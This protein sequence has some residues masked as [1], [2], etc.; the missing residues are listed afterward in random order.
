MRLKG[1]FRS[2]LASVPLVL[3]GTAAQGQIPAFPGA[4][5]ARAYAIGGRGSDVYHVVNLSDTGPGSLRYGV[6]DA[7]AAGRAIVFEVSGWI[8]IPSGG[9]IRVT[10]PKITIAGQT[11]PSDGVGLYNGTFGRRAQ[12]SSR[13]ARHVHARHRARLHQHRQARIASKEAANDPSHFHFSRVEQSVPTFTR[14]GDT[15]GSSRTHT[16][17][18]INSFLF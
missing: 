2:V 9:R 7:P 14:L 6:E 15:A 1:R 11:A 8:R 16:R 5:G 12:I 3:A 4:V 17:I 18:C 13:G 10:R